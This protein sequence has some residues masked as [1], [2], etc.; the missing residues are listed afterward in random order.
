MLACYLKTM[1]VF[2]HEFKKCNTDIYV[3]YDAALLFGAALLFAV[4]FR[5]LFAP[6]Y[7]VAGGLPVLA[8]RVLPLSETWDLFFFLVFISNMYIYNQFL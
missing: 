4:W 5:S 1:H 6:G 7:R 2:F 8:L 3:C